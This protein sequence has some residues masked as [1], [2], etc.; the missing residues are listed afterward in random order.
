MR[1]LFAIVAL[2]GVSSVSAQDNELKWKHEY[3]GPSL[4]VGDKEITSGGFNSLRAQ[5]EW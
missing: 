3:T 4:I 5:S 2:L 1:S